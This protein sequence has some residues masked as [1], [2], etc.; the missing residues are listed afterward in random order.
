MTTMVIVSKNFFSFS[1]SF[2]RHGLLCHQAE[3]FLIVFHHFHHYAFDIMKLSRKIIIKIV[4]K[5]PFATTFH[6]CGE[7]SRHQM[8]ENR[9]IDVE[10][11]T[12]GCPKHPLETLEN[13]RL[14]RVA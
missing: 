10:K 9:M 12:L 1:P 4:T 8:S 3:Y 2:F 13:K 14:S 5:S 7:R 6:H 11:I